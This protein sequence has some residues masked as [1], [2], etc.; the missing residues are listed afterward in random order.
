MDVTGRYGG[1][2]LSQSRQMRLGDRACAVTEVRGCGDL[3]IVVDLPVPL[4]K[5]LLADQQA[6]MEE[7]RLIP[8]PRSPCVSDVLAQYAESIMPASAD[9]N[10]P[11]EEL[12]SMF[13]LRPS[14]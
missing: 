11:E 9:A 6:I 1:C 4:K 3:Q 10:N 12:V 8:L 13:C 14:N 5:I 7:S 2:V